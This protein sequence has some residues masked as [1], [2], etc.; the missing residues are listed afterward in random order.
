VCINIQRLIKTLAVCCT[1]FGGAECPAHTGDEKIKVADCFVASWLVLQLSERFILTSCLSGSNCSWHTGL[2]GICSFFEDVFMSGLNKHG[3]SASGRCWIR[4]SGDEPVAAS[5][6]LVLDGR[7][8]ECQD[9]AKL[10]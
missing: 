7:S 1:R 8:V 6:G 3:G 5:G 4:A 2:A 10:A 9:C